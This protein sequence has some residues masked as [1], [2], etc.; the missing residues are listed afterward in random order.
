MKIQTAHFGERDIDESTVITF[1]GG[2]PGFDQKTRFALLPEEVDPPVFYFLQSIEDP[3][4][5]FTV[6]FSEKFGITFDESVLTTDEMASLGLAKY[7]DAVVILLIS[8]NR[9][10]PHR[11]QFDPK[12]VPH[13]SHPLVIN[14]QTRKGIYKA[15]NGVRCSAT[16]SAT[17]EPGDDGQGAREDYLRF[18]AMMQAGITAS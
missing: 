5:A 15:L 12:F 1:N 11:R 3:D 6:S 4:L 2:L 18:L 14:P 17:A 10:H 13:I 7:D 16:V 8:E 9:E